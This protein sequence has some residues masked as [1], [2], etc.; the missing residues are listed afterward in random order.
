[1]KKEIN[2][3]DC[4]I[5]N[6]DTEQAVEM[7][8]KIDAVLRADVSIDEALSAEFLDLAAWA[9]I[10]DPTRYVKLKTRVP[11][12]VG[13]RLFEK[14]VQKVAVGRKEKTSLKFLRLSG[15]ETHGLLVPEDWIVDDDG[16]RHLE[17]NHGALE[18][19][20]ISGDPV[21]I[22][23]ILKN[24]DDDKEFLELTFR[25][26]GF[27]KKLV[28]PRMDF[29]NRNSIIRFADDGFPVF[30][31][32]TGALTKFIA[33]FE[34]S[35][36]D[37]IPVLRAINRAGWIGDEFYPYA[38]EDGLSLQGDGGE[39]ENI[40][41]A[42]KESGLEETWL[43]TAEK[44]REMP[45][46]RTIVAAS[47]ASPLLEKLHHRNIFIHD[48]YGSRSGKTAVLKFA[49]SVWGDP[50]LLLGSYNSTLV[51]LERKAGTLRNLPLALDELQTLNRKKLPVNDIVYNLGNGVGKTRG[52]IKA[53]IQKM[54]SWSNCILST[55]EQPMSTENSMDGINTRLL[56]IY[57]CPLNKDG[58]GAVDDALAK[59]LHQVAES[60]Y[61]FAGYKFI[62]WVIE[63]MD[64][65]GADY[66]NI[67][68]A[69][70]CNSSK[71]DSIAV[72]ALA[73]FYSSVA[74]FELPEDQAF[75]EAVTLGKLLLKNQEENAPIDSIE[76]A[77]E[78]ICGWVASNQAHFSGSSTEHEL[79]PTYGRIE[80]D[81]VLVIVKEMNRALEEAGFQHRKCVSG[82]RER[83]YIKTFIDKRSQDT[84]RINGF[85]SKVY[86]LN[87]STKEAV[88]VE[89]GLPFDD[90]PDTVLEE[91]SFFEP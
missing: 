89:D 56:E 67:I 80:D 76:S 73:D 42:L 20:T 7:Q 65:L 74:V 79:S 36:E 78:F 82:F 50:N 60:N 1:M 55:G 49:M 3:C 26:N 75:S 70:D 68:R 90:D 12:A 35:N 39:P 27:Y 53:G 29:L 41:S 48:W 63:H 87:I 2:G 83:E 88:E 18:T 71:L 23:A 45:F 46:A 31:A 64:R 85:V 4:V 61:G 40:L 72:L 15:I 17:S 38:M 33:E 84:A 58:T 37:V 9:K 59:E 28:A 25:R 51:G 11:K 69:L 24:V 43:A 54:E 16:I 19:V 6:V 34:R 91:L 21:F 22:S 5:G 77:W 30:S 13:A 81:A 32:N 57:A 86:V 44:V 62:R 66:S 14:E 10:H 8:D 47:F 52:Q